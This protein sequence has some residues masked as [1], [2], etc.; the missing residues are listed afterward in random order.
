MRFSL[1]VKHRSARTKNGHFPSEIGNLVL[2][3]SLEL[4]GF[5][6]CWAGY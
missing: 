5:V 6:Q 3:D 1:P 2:N 4:G